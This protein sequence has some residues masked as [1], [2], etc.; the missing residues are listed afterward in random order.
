MIQPTE[1]Y[2]R[3]IDSIHF[4]REMGFFVEFNNLTNEEVIAEVLDVWGE[5]NLEDTVSPGETQPERDCTILACDR[6]RVWAM[7]FE[8]VLR[9]ADTYVEVIHEWAAISRRV[10]MPKKI[11]EIWPNVEGDPVRIMFT[12]GV[13]D[14]T[15][16]HKNGSD[17]Y[18]DTKVLRVINQ[19]I[20]HTPYRFEGCRNCIDVCRCILVLTAE[21]KAKLAHER[22]WTF[23]N[24]L[25]DV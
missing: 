3:V 1:N 18:I 5:D 7:S 10:F 21:E 24:W 23:C 2:N 13:Q 20:A 22:G 6:S 4:F 16:I 9:G 11:R 19:S 15:F 14:Y 8:G 25:S 17:D 12:V